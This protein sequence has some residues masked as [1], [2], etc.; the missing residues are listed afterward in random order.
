MADDF[1][2]PK[3]ADEN[4]GSR[5]SKFRFKSSRAD[6][7]R[8]ET[9]SGSE[10][11]KH[12]KRRRNRSP[13]P[14]HKK[15]TRTSRKPLGDDPSAYDDT[16]LPNSRSTQFQDP[17]VAFRE[18]LFDALADDEGAAYW[19]GVYGQPIHVYPDTKPGPEGKLERMTDEEYTEYVRSRMWEKS[20]QHL[21][22][23]RRLREEQRRKNK[24]AEEERQKLHSERSTFDSLIDDALRRG[25]K[26]KKEQGWQQSWSRYT[27]KWEALVN[28][29]QDSDD[30]VNALIPWPVQT[31]RR[32]DV[33]KEEV[34]AFFRK[35]P[36]NELGTLLKLER[37]R[38]H[39]D[40][41]QQRI[42]GLRLDEEV[43][44]AVTAVFQIVDSMWVSL[45]RDG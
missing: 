3:S 19:E 5:K 22:E 31:G 27:S 38:W 40:K 43:S 44:R 36:P 41:M 29:S 2:Q 11:R 1:D 8:S 13:S 33:S 34:E 16:Y 37:V 39:P 4:T 25:N 42:P 23:E 45:K 21:I 12:G 7:D 24:E 15:R 30:S 17:D 14:R 6:R 35:N 20:H 32:K 26:R 9:H 10:H 18:S 28:H